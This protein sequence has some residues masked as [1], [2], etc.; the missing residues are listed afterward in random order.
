MTTLR[1]SYP[2]KIKKI[3]TLNV[4]LFHYIKKQRIKCSILIKTTNQKSK[5]SGHHESINFPNLALQKDEFRVSCCCLWGSQQF[6]I[7][8]IYFVLYFLL[9]YK[10]KFLDFK[11]FRVCFKKIILQGYSRVSN[12][13]LQYMCHFSSKEHLKPII[14]QYFIYKIYYRYKFKQIIYLSAVKLSKVLEYQGNLK[15]LQISLHIRNVS[16]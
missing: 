4:F 8:Q 16:V 3:F 11:K 5:V 1:Y 9:P 14:L 12:V 6:G 13:S 2:Q 7:L 10:F 15:T